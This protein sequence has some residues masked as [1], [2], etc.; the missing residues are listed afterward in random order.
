[1]NKHL[2]FFQDLGKFAV[3]L[4]VLVVLLNWEKFTRPYFFEIPLEVR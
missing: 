2:Y 3:D 1:M 4:S